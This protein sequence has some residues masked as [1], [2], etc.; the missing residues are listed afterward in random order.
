MRFSPPL[1]LALCAASSLFAEPAEKPLGR[2]MEQRF[3]KIDQNLAFDPRQGA[4]NQGRT[5]ATD[6]ARVA[7]FNYDQKARTSRFETREFAQ[8]KTSWLSKLKFWVKDANVGGGHEIPNVSRQVETKPAGVKG[9]YDADKAMAVRNLPGGDRTYLG[10]ERAKL[11]RAVD[12]NKPLSGWSGD[13]MEPMT[14]E[15]V[16]ELLNKNK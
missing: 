14:L 11:D 12:P 15:Q 13:K 4:V 1:L 16:R 3:G 6:S 8:P 9:A 5:I 2:T 10:P 7:T